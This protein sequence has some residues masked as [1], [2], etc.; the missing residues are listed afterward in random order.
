M[1]VPDDRYVLASGDDGADRLAVVN[2]VHGADTAAFLGRA[3]LRPGMRVADIGCGIGA[4]SRWMAEQ[5]GPA[6]EVWGIDIHPDQVGVASRLSSEAGVGNARF[7][8]GAAQA[9]GLPGDS[10]DLV[11]CRFVLM[12][13]AEPMAALQEMLGLLRPGGVL[14]CEDSD[15]TSPFCEPDHPDYRRLFELY[16]ALGD[17][18]GLDFRIGPKLY[19]YFLE[20][21]LEDVQVALAQPVAVR[22]QVK[23]LPGRTVE[24]CAPALL[25]AGLAAA[26]EL[27]RLADGI[28]V[29]ESDPTV[30]FGM[31][32]MTQVHGRRPARHASAAG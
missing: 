2:A 31:A 11:F 16:L 24:E 29:L 4:V 8:V 14:A 3:G 18:K 32:Q 7:Q 10:F 26:D 28:A 19:R 23:R 25:E 12:H 6:G 22:G 30:L 9:T 13:V 17:R 20:L 15:F 5:V 1:G 27:R 21:G